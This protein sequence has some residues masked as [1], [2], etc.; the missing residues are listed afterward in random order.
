[1]DFIVSLPRTQKGHDAV[2]VVV[3]TLT[4]IAR[5]IATKI[6]VTAP[7]LDYQFIDE[8]FRFYGLPMDIVSDRDPKFTNDFWTQ[9]FKKL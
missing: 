5:F 8:L 7:E 4:K 9:V 2:W 3:D 6:T 1:M